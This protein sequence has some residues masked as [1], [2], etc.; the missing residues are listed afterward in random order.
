MFQLIEN[1][2]LNKSNRITLN[3]IRYHTRTTNTNLF[4]IL[5]PHKL[6]FTHWR[7]RFH[8]TNHGDRGCRPSTGNRP[9]LSVHCSVAEWGDVAL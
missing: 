1:P 3:Y 6:S 8:I 9:K 5:K 2:V 7:V 4:H